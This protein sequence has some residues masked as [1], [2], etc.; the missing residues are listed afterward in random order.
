MRNILFILQKEFKQVFRNRTMLPIIFLMPV[1][2]MVILVHAA[3]M[4]MKKIE[5]VIVD[6]DMSNVSRKLTARFEG[7]PFFVVSRSS[8][9]VE[10]AENY[11]K[12]NTA[13]VVLHIPSG[14]ERRLMRENT[15]D[16]QC[17]INA[18]NSTTAGLIQAYTGGI[19]LTFNNDITE[20]FNG[21]GGKAQSKSLVSSRFWYNQELDYKI[22]MLPGIL[23]ILVTVIGAFLTALNIVREKEMGTIEQI[24]VTPVK[25]YEFITG[26]LIP[27][28]MIA[29][30][31]FCI[32]LGIGYFFFD[33]PVNGSLLTLFAVTSVYLILALGIGLFL[34]AISQT[35]QQVMF[36][37][38]FFM[39][40]FILM[41]GIFT[42]AESMPEWAQKVNIINPFFYYMKALRM[43]LLKGSSFY[44]ILNEFIS[45]LVYSLVMLSLATW[46][47]RKTI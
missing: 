31:E 16:I 10:E 9:S 2:Q 5:M 8:L 6:R 18:I 24:N 43:I 38:F 36:V 25:K 37:V 21:V 23:V 35:Q 30:L 46:R 29:L 27:F 42:P 11:I 13:D 14:F 26:K 19:I 44:D 32:G 12:D 22:Y 7:S 20:K 1:V 34:S 3:T 39:L 28:W 4:E 45:L 17:L 33:L 41:S 47:Y 40:V 15:A